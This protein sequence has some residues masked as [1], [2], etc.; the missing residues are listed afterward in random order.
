MTS[1]NVLQAA[2]WWRVRLGSV[3]L[4]LRDVKVT[5]GVEGDRCVVSLTWPTP[6]P[7]I[8]SERRAPVFRVPR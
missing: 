5:T 3:V 8:G 7:V 1:L 2:P 6:T 4:D